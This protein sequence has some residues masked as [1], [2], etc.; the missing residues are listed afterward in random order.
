MNAF[1]TAVMRNSFVLEFKRK[2]MREY[3]AHFDIVGFTYY[4]GVLTFSELKTGVQ[5][6]LKL[7]EENKFDTRAIAI[8]YKEF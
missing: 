1:C 5:L 3:L 8:Y 6:Q 2:V 4:E 7:K